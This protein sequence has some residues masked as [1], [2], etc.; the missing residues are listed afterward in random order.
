MSEIIAQKILQNDELRRNWNNQRE[1]LDRFVDI[2]IDYLNQLQNSHLSQFP[3][4]QS[5]PPKLNY[6]KKELQIILQKHRDKHSELGTFYLK[7]QQLI[8]LLTTETVNHNFE[9]EKNEIEILDKNLTSKWMKLNAFSE[10][11]ENCGTLTNQLFYELINLNKWLNSKARTLNEI[12]VG[13]STEEKL[14][15]NQLIV[16]QVNF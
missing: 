4:D 13:S 14:I 3:S 15:N 9:K 11:L 1:I 7:T 2:E 6:L 8:T 10:K 5:D 16:L 12:C